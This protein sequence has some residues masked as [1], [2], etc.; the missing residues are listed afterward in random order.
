[1]YIDILSKNTNNSTNKLQL[2]YVYIATYFMQCRYDHL[3]AKVFACSDSTYS[4]I[5]DWGDFGV[6]KFSTLRAEYKYEYM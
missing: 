1:M 6:H 3:S 4:S 5:M 2:K